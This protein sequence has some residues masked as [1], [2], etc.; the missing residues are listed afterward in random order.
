MGEFDPDEVKLK[1][2]RTFEH[3]R[4]L[5]QDIVARGRARTSTI[6]GSHTEGSASDSGVTRNADGEEVSNSERSSGNVADTTNWTESETENENITHAP[7]L[8][9][10]EDSETSSVQFRNVEEQLYRAMSTMVNQPTQQAL[11][12][13]PGAKT[14]EIITPTLKDLFVRS[15]RR[16]A[17]EID[18]YT[19]VPFCLPTTTAQT[20]IDERTAQI[21]QA[22]SQFA[23]QAQPDVH[24][25]PDNEP[26]ATRQP[27]RGA[28]VT[29][30]P[31]GT[32]AASPRTKREK[33]P[34]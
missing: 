7:F 8:H 19:T 11:L 14:R 5:W 1:L 18:R 28:V 2:D 3:H 16:R 15:T 29:L 23:V 4:L 31:A 30:K 27:K 10:E 17:Y 32:T 12:K 6:G 9:P 13:V 22:R 34:T 20:I 26:P 24:S 33:E 21:L 25:T